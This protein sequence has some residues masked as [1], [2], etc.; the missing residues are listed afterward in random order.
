MGVNLDRLS[1]RQLKLLPQLARAFGEQVAQTHLLASG[2]YDIS[3]VRQTML[4][5]HFDGSIIS[6]CDFQRR[7]NMQ[8]QVRQQNNQGYSA[9]GVFWG[10]L[11]GLQMMEA[12][13]SETFLEE[14]SGCAPETSGLSTEYEDGSALLLL[15]EDIRKMMYPHASLG[16]TVLDRAAWLYEELAGRGLM[17][18]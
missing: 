1:V 6:S 16:D 11:L 3:D 7:L 5:R 12:L 4:G 18:G 10:N 15:T 14:Y 2:F 9:G 8:L 17:Y 13:G